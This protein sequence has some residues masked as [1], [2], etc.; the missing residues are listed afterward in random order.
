MSQPNELECSVYTPQVVWKQPEYTVVW[1]SEYR[2]F[3][4]LL[5]E[6]AFTSLIR[7][8]HEGEDIEEQI[9]NDEYNLWEEHAIDYESE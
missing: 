6:G 9:E 4:Y 8:M 1:L 5:Q 7:F 3:G 2:T